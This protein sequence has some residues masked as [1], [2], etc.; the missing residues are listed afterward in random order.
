MKI[1]QVYKYTTKGDP[2]I[3]AGTKMRV[4]SF[5]QRGIGVPYVYAVK[6]SSK[7]KQEYVIMAH[8]LEECND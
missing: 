7:D 4:V 6:V 2:A 8:E 3:P 5:E 1:G